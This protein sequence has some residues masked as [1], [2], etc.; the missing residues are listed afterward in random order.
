MCTHL[1]TFDDR[2]WVYRVHHGRCVGLCENCVHLCV[3]VFAH[4][5]V[6]LTT[7]SEFIACTMAVTAKIKAKFVRL[8]WFMYHY[9][10]LLS[11]VYAFS[12]VLPHMR[13]PRLSCCVRD[14]SKC[15]KC[16]RKDR[17]RIHRTHQDCQ[18]SRKSTFR[19]GCFVYAYVSGI[20]VCMNVHVCVC[21]CTYTIWPMHT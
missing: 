11:H 9:L 2:V 6:P 7:V 8:C 17:V 4:I 15:F 13:V 10:W 20:Y 1:R 5:Y 16:N 21:V 19:K 3:C 18:C 14:S 12:S